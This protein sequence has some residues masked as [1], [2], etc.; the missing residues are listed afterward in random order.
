MLS[1]LTLQNSRSSRPA[2]NIFSVYIQYATFIKFALSERKYQVATISYSKVLTDSALQ[3]DFFI[4][5]HFFL[6]NAK[7]KVLTRPKP[8]VNMQRIHSGNADA[9]N[10]SE[11]MNSRQ[12]RPAND[13]MSVS[14][15]YSLNNI[16]SHGLTLQK[17]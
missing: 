4:H 3:V 17:S 14:S 6:K 1:L 13:S 9:V 10:T 16:I 11:T 7:I 12:S 15:I 2:K 8:S 5:L